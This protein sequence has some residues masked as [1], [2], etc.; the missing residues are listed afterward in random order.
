MAELPG[1]RRLVLCFF[2]VSFRAAIAFTLVL[3]GLGLAQATRPL[4]DDELDVLVERE[5]GR[6][7]DA[8]KS[9]Q[10]RAAHAL[11]ERYFAEPSARE[12]VLRELEALTLAPDDLSHL[13]RVRRAW[14]PLAA[15]LREIEARHGPLPVH[16]FLDVPDGYDRL[17]SSPLVIVL[18]P[19]EAYLGRKL[20][21]GAETLRRSA[22]WMALHRRRHPD[23][24]LLMPVLDRDLLV[25]P[26]YLGMNQ[27]IQPMLHVGELVNFDPARVYLAGHSVSAVLAWNLVLHYPTYFA[28]VQVLAGSASAEWQRLRLPNLRNLRVVVWHDVADKVIPV[29]QARTIVGILRRLKYDVHYS[30]TRALGHVPD[31][32]VMSAGATLLRGAVRTLRPEV[33]TLQSN[34]YEPQ[35]NRADWVQANQPLRPGDESRMIVARG[36]DAVVLFSMPMRV[37][38]KLLDDNRVEVRAE[39]V[40]SLRLFLNASMVDPD[41]PVVVRLNGKVEFEGQVSPS[42]RVALRDQLVLGRGWRAYTIAIDLPQ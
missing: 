42:I 10:Y 38:A 40:D 22:A 3:C 37:E 9:G 16:Y 33:V 31:D 35:F 8:S 23:A 41:R 18:P 2:S 5:L 14:A 21:P 12:S 17:R 25:G 27:V 36:R 6:R 19:P 15:G 20:E 30:E 32:A 11:I 7:W 39:N 4:T 26:S 29:A 28:G 1:F 24:L 13:A 34:R